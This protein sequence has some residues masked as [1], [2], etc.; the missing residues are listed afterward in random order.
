MSA[1]LEEY[2]K[3]V[4]VLI[5]KNGTARVTD[6]ACSLSCSKPSV[7]RAI[8]LLKE[9]GFI[10]YESYGDILLT[11]KGK[12]KAKKIV[13]RHEIIKGFLVQVLEVNE[14]VADKEANTM[15]YAVSEDTIKKFEEYIKTI[16]D[17]D[18]L[19][20]EY[21]SKSE[22]CKKCIKRTTQYRYEKESKK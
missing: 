16:I 5:A 6:I 4:Y 2:L 19:K 7:N 10:D 3:T 13:K 21:N 8:K 15:K 9:D 14:I 22:K 1:T 18:Q 20:C 11:T 17:V 12:E